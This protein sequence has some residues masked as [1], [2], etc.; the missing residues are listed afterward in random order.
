MEG[1]VRD[2]GSADEERA[3]AL[4][5]ALSRR[6]RAGTPLTSVT[7][8]EVTSDLR[9]METADGNDAIQIRPGEDVPF[10]ARRSLDTPAREMLSLYLPLCVG[11]RTTDL[12]VGHL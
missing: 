12:V 9:V 2:A 10:A 1:S 5:L 6:A 4:L 3:W 11:L 8:F 7:A